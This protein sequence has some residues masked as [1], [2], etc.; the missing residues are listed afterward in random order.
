M[1]VCGWTF[2]YTLSRALA[3]LQAGLYAHT[4]TR[5]HYMRART[6]TLPAHTD[7]HTHAFSADNVD[8][9]VKNLAQRLKIL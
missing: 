1:H 3:H 2:V 7:I 8:E 4:H 5:S 9:Y 6:H